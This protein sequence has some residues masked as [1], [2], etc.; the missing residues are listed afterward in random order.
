MVRIDPLIR[1]LILSIT[2]NQISDLLMKIIFQE[3]TMYM[4]VLLE[5]N[6]M[7]LSTDISFQQWT[8]IF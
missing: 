6:G 5:V 8:K 3:S 1:L 4:L 7:F 2:Y